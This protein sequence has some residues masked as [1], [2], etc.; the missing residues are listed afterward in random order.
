MRYEL[1]YWPT[2]QGRG[3]FV[4]LALEDAGADYLDVGNGSEADEL[5]VPAIVSYLDG[6]A[7]PR[8]PFA[9]PFLK[10]GELVISHV[11]NILQYLGPRLAL[12]P[13][14]EACRYWAHGLQLTITDLV[15][16]IHDCHHPIAASLYYQDQKDEALRRSQILRD[17]RLPRFLGYFEQVLEQNPAGPDWLVGD[18]HSYVDLSLFQVI[19]GLRYAF[20]KAMAAQQ[21]ALPKVDALAERVAARPRIQAY[22]ESDRRLPFNEDGIFRHYP[23]LDG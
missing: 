19:S 16:E 13:D 6:D 23:E 12:V 11:A 15:A 17:E 10:A 2:I 4:R 5:G 21:E 20:P 3:E 9:P 22:L 18:A 7:T 8:P 14:D 1:F